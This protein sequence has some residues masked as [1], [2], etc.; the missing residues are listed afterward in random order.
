MAG[1]G[2]EVFAAAGGGAF[3]GSTVGRFGLL[4]LE[5]VEVGLAEAAADDVEMELDVGGFFVGQ[6][7]EQM[8]AELLARGATETIAAPDFAERVDAG[9]AAVD[10]IGELRGKQW[11]GAGRL[12]WPT[13]SRRGAL[14]R[15][16]R[17]GRFG[18]TWSSIHVQINHGGTKARRRKGS[19]E[20]GRKTFI[21][22]AG[23][24]R[25]REKWFWLFLPFE[26]LSWLLG[27]L[28]GN[29]AP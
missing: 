14:R 25:K 5:V 22:K 15:G 28:I 18:R 10:E 13:W 24:E 21:R 6:G 8:A 27:F 17:L 3:G 1:A 26:I 29:S 11:I 23:M 2:M 4:R 19:D 7:T 12:R 20:C 9:V 16:R